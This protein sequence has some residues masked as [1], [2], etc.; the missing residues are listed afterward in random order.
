MLTVIATLPLPLAA[1]AAGQFTGMPGDTANAPNSFYW[2]GGYWGYCPPPMPVTAQAPAPPLPGA[3]TTAGGV[4]AG[5]GVPGGC[6]S[7][8][9]SPQANTE[10][11]TNEARGVA[12]VL[13]D[14]QGSAPGA[15]R[16]IVSVSHVAAGFFC[17]LLVLLLCAGCLLL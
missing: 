7:V 14:A 1:T 5:A 11:Q 8:I 16:T 10:F 6:T 15:G 9:R 13:L 4:L 2:S 12:P 3:G 17:F